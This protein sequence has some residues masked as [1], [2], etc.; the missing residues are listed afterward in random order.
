MKSP[1]SYLK[2][3]FIKRW[4]QRQR[5]SFKPHYELSKKLK[6]PILGKEVRLRRTSF[7][8]I[9]GFN[10]LEYF[11]AMCKVVKYRGC[12][13]QCPLHPRYFNPINGRCRLPV[14]TL[15]RRRFPQPTCDRR[16]QGEQTTSIG[17]KEAKP[18]RIQGR[19]FQWGNMQAVFL[20]M[21]D[22]RNQHGK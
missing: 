7:P 9:G 11:I 4:Q 22:Y 5:K 2:P 12:R 21:K 1:I 6:P 16:I 3:R 13:G 14:D 20:E 8:K 17:Q 10:F 19:C 18:Q 15:W